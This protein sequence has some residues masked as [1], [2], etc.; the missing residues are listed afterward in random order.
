MHSSWPSSIKNVVLVGPDFPAITGGSTYMENFGMALLEAGINVSALSVY[1]GPVA[2][3]L[4]HK[5][6]FERRALQSRPVVGDAPFSQKLLKS[7]IVAFKRLE[8]SYNLRRTRRWLESM[9]AD[10]VIVFTHVSPMALLSEAGFDATRCDALFV[11]QHHSSFAS[12]QMEPRLTEALQRHFANFSCFT[13]LSATDA[14]L[15]GE[16][17]DAPTWAI[18]NPTPSIPVLHHRELTARRKRAVALARYSAEKRLPLMIEGFATATWQAG[19]EGWTLELYGEGSEEK[20]LRQSIREHEAEDRIFVMGRT[21]D[22]DSVLANSQLNLL[23]SAFE[24]FGFSVLEA[25]RHSVPSIAFDVSPGLTNLMTALNGAL[26]PRDN[27]PAFTSR[28]SELLS[29]S[30][31]REQAGADALAGSEKFS[32][33]KIVGLWAEMLNSVLP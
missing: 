19:I 29:N 6:I 24:G 17:I 13:A 32:G 14:K 2:T 11:G 30:A 22:V 1:R 5:V 25:G 21:D 12:A 18:P 4:S 20:R 23:T 15:F 7:P 8:R 16:L 3:N 27:L 9:S 26:I 33:P 31:Q 28:L 10:T